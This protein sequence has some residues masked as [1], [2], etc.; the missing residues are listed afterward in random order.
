MG[1]KLS[2]LFFCSYTASVADLANRAV[3]TKANLPEHTLEQ[4]IQALNEPMEPTNPQAIQPPSNHQLAA[5]LSYIDVYMDDFIGLS[6]APTKR[7][8]QRAILHSIDTQYFVL[9]DTR[10]TPS[11]AKMS[12]HARNWQTES[13]T[14][15]DTNS[16]LP[17][18]LTYLP[19]Q[20]AAAPR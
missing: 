11:T 1:W 19:A 4:V 9:R 5:P 12:F 14:T 8:T 10:T 16:D 17:K 2:P 20:V 7:H 15:N 3:Q 13:R 6:Q 18:P